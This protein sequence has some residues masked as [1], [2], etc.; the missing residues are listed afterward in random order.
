MLFIVVAPPAHVSS[1][2]H[3]APYVIATCE[4]IPQSDR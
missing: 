1:I 3:E 4:E 2:Q